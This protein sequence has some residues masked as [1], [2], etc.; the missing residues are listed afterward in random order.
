MLGSIWNHCFTCL[1]GETKLS[2]IFPEQIKVVFFM[3]TEINS[4]ILKSFGFDIF[5]VRMTLNITTVLRRGS[6]LTTDDLLW[7]T[8]A[9]WLFWN[10]TV[11]N[12]AC[13]K[14]DM[15]I[16]KRCSMGNAKSRWS[17]SY[18]HNELQV[19]KNVCN[20]NIFG[21]PDRETLIFCTLY[22]N[23]KV[24]KKKNKQDEFVGSCMTV[25]F[26]SKHR[27]FFNQ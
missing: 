15:D 12:S 20:N 6:R 25:A 26:T 5:F 17:Y 8:A 16:F 3:A 21:M 14:P 18:E 27:A 4:R 1:L 11:F 22:F 24:K 2:A 7:G 23:N 13:K 19:F 10:Y 9:E